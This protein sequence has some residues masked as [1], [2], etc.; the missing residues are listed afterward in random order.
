M[1]TLRPA[2]AR[3]DCA[4]TSQISQGREYC[5]GS[6]TETETSQIIQRSAVNTTTSKLFTL[7][8]YCKH[9][10]RKLFFYCFLLSLLRIKYFSYFTISPCVS[11]LNVAPCHD[12]K[13]A[14]MFV[15]AVSGAREPV[16]GWIENILLTCGGLVDTGDRLSALS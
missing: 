15:P 11:G 14:Y 4:A 12:K 3:T 6:G 5:D 2:G 7:Q 9:L 16:T 13:C 10:I 8:F 1:S